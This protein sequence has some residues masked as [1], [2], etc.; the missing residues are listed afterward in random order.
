MTKLFSPITVGSLEVRNRIWIA[1]MCMYSC[2]NRDGVPTDFHLAHL[3]AR[4]LGGAGLIF[5]EASAVEAI[6]RI[7]P[8]DAGIWN[9]DQVVGWQRVTALIHASGAKVAMQLAHAGRKASTH[10]GWSGDGSI[11]AADGGWQSVSSTSEA[12]D[13]YAAPRELSTA[14]VELLPALFA[15][16]ATR[17][18]EAGFDAV[19]LHA[20][21]GYLIHEF[22]S[23]LTNQRQ[24]QFGGSLENRAR[25]L[26]DTVR[27]V[28]A[29]LPAGMPLM[30]RFSGTD[31]VDGGWDIASTAQVAKWC[32]V[33]GADMFDISS[34]G[35]V[36]GAKIP[37]GPGYQ[38]PLAEY[39]AERVG[40]PVSAVGQITEGA[41]AEAILQD[42]EVS[43]ILIGR[44]SL[45]EPNWPIR[46][47]HEL[48]V[49]IDYVP[50]QYSRAGW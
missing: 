30:I 20:A 26:L 35:L 49:S 13:G 19:Q 6:G 47:A 7:T 44:A 24:D 9:Q 39:V 34:G 37:L 3:G 27:A 46:V 8:W 11:S 4:A 32:E 36:V 23:P 50:N 31:Y 40:E 15:A 12:F 25:L 1:P 45:R 17:S 48:G 2:E 14:E 16:A 28:R 21:H 33:E 18:V 41:Q 10:R 43:V 5:V 22:L 29:V 42:G 38:V